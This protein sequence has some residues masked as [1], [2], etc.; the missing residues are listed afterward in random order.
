MDLY[1]VTPMYLDMTE[2]LKFYWEFREKH[3]Y[4]TVY[5]EVERE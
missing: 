3:N 5:S 1:P 2:N 4:Q